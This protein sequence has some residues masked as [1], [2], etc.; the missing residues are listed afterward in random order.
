MTKNAQ[1][2]IRFITGAS[3][4]LG[5]SLARLA[6]AR[7]ERV[8]ATGRRSAPLQELKTLGAEV[9]L[10]DLT[11]PAAISAAVAAARERFGGVDVLVN[12]AGY[13]LVGAIEE[14]SDAETR[15]QFDVN[16]FGLM[17]VTRAVLPSMRERGG[18]RIVNFS[19]LAGFLGMAGAGN[20]CASKFAVEG[21]SETLAVELVPFG[22]KVI[23]VEPGSFKTNFVER[24]R[25]AAAMEAY[26]PTVGL[27]RAWMETDAP[28]NG[29][30]PDRA[31]AAVFA[32]VDAQSCRCGSWLA[33]TRL[34][35][36]APSSRRCSRAWTLGPMSR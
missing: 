26:A 1:A 23:I 8:F 35:A 25:I 14:T 32:A 6:L 20:Y 12:S 31:A 28:R 33:K 10:M 27:L 4:G 7:G 22:I 9:A 15:A 21:L 5:L 36:R 19:S 24:T 3:S 34:Q 17:N 11:Q 16:V 29:A 30:D 18:G 2:R 13:A